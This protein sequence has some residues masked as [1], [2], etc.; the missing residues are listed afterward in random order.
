LLDATGCSVLQY[1]SPLSNAN[2]QKPGPV[3]SEVRACTVR[4]QVYSG[5][6][7]TYRPFS[8]ILQ[9]DDLQIYFRK[10]VCIFLHEEESP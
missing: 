2:V 6:R 5:A 1:R 8:E 3:Q 9:S 7:A 4:S 10:T